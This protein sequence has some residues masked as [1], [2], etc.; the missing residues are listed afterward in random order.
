MDR[1]QAV[2]GIWQSSAHNHGHGILHD[3]NCRVTENENLDKHVSAGVAAES[4]RVGTHAQIRLLSLSVELPFNDLAIRVIYS[5]QAEASMMMDRMFLHCNFFSTAAVCWKVLVYRIVL[6]N[7]NIHA[8]R[9]TSE[10]R[11]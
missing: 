7:S 6:H 4:A 11:T 10:A 8:R 5:V 2:S 9:S 1:L 3:K